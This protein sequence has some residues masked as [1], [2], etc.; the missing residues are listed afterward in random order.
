MANGGGNEL[1]GLLLSRLGGG[2]GK[3]SPKKKKPGLYG[4]SEETLGQME[5]RKGRMETGVQQYD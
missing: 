1:G 4:K 5:R 2:M 3:S